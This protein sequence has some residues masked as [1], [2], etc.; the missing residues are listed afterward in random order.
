MRAKLQSIINRF[1]MKG[2]MTISKIKDE[3]NKDAA[4][5]NTEAA[6]QAAVEKA[7]AAAETEVSAM[8]TAL[9]EAV[10]E[11]APGYD[12]SEASD[13]IATALAAGKAEVLLKHASQ[14]A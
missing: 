10:E 3:F 1:V 12:L 14:S 4:A 5:S 6:L 8:T 9:T 2:E 7:G 11:I 13:A